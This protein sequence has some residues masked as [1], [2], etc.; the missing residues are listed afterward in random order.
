MFAQTVVKFITDGRDNVHLV[1]SG[2]QLQKMLLTL[3][4]HLLQKKLHIK[5]NLLNALKPAIYHQAIVSLKTNKFVR[6]LPGG[7]FSL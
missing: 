4:L 7:L 2:T 5:Y 6:I 1:K 3:L